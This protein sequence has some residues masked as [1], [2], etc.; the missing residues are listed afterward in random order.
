[1]SDNKVAAKPA[2]PPKT[3][4]TTSKTENCPTAKGDGFNQMSTISS[5]REMEIPMKSSNVTCSLKTNSSNSLCQNKT[6]GHELILKES[7]NERLS[8]KATCGK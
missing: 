7:F 6:L 5:G 3:E 4:D 8:S 2:P 1:M